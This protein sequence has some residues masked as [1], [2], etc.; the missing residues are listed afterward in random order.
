VFP[1]GEVSPVDAVLLRLGDRVKECFFNFSLRATAEQTSS[2]GNK[3]LAIDAKTVY[4]GRAYVAPLCSLLSAGR[5]S[6]PKI[7]AE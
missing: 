2:S 5:V 6:P 3:L 7:P 1:H 4:L